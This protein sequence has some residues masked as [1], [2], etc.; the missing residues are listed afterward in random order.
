MRVVALGGVNCAVRARCGALGPGENTRE[1][2]V[3]LFGAAFVVATRCAR[4]AYTPLGG[5]LERDPKAG[6]LVWAAMV[7]WAHLGCIWGVWGG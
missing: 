1:T 5:S 6:S 3:F 2:V 4:G 7:T